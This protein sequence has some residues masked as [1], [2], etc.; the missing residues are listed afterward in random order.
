MRKH[1]EL[2]VPTS[3]LN[4]SADNEPIFVLCARDPSA[5]GAV[6]QWANA[7]KRRKIA[8][9]QFFDAAIRKHREALTLADNMELWRDAQREAEEEVRREM[10]T[11]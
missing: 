11:G 8:A 2:T 1:F 10:G 5:P 9:N 6:R 7:Y 3:C 4:R